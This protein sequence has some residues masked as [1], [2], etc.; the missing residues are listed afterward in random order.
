MS[1]NGERGEMKFV[2]GETAKIPKKNMVS[3]SLVHNSTWSDRNSNSRTQRSRGR[4]VSWPFG[5]G[6]GARIIITIK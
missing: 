6:H 3:T 4:P 5:P 2:G 1:E